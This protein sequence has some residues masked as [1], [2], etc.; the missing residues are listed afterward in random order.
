M[1]S[2]SFDSI[3]FEPPNFVHNSADNL[4]DVAMEEPEIAVEDVILKPADFTSEACPKHTNRATAWVA[5][6]TA[7]KATA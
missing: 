3:G 2:H 1:S 4:T 6:G 7:H 5:G